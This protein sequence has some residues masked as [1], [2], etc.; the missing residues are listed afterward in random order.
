MKSLSIRLDG[1][2]SDIAHLSEMF[3][4]PNVIVHGGNTHAMANLEVCVTSAK[5]FVQTASS[6]V[7]AR[8]AISEG[9]RSDHG[10]LTDQKRNEISS[11]IPKPTS[12]SH[13]GTDQTTQIGSGGSV[14]T[15]VITATNFDREHA[16]LQTLL[17]FSREAYKGRQFEEAKLLLQRFRKR[18]EARYGGNFDERNEVLSMLA[19]IHCRLG[20]YDFA[21]EIIQNSKFEGRD[22]VIKSLVFS[23]CEDGRW[24]NAERILREL[25]DLEG[26]REMDSEYMLGELY[27]VRGHYDKAIQSCDKIIQ[28]LGEEHVLFY[29]SLSLLAQIYDAKGDTIEAR[30]HRDLVP[31]GIEGSSKFGNVT[32]YQPVTSSI[33]FRDFGLIKLRRKHNQLGLP[34]FPISMIQFHGTKSKRTF[35]MEI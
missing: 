25:A 26:T 15:S 3:Q 17:K 20:E 24:D 31:P 35:H 11:W 14:I 10:D 18:S 6:I 1:L 22:K 19:M 2:G 34:Y 30:L 7:N 23:Y 33:D 16:N 13:D 32:D 4:Q 5:R 28:F 12:P 29:M 8:L 27:L 21:E 9:R